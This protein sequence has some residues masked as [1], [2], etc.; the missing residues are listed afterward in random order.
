MFRRGLPAFLEVTLLVVL[1][2]I[3][4]RCRAEPLS[5]GELVRRTQECQPT[6]Q[7]YPEDIKAQIGARPIAEWG[8]EP[9]E[10][11]CEGDSLSVVFRLEGPWAT[12]DAVIPVLLKDPRGGVRRHGET[13]RDGPLVTYVFTL[14]DADTQPSWLEVLYPTGQRRIALSQ[15]GQWKK[16]E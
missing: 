9:V 13:R 4:A 11:G 5:Q 2:M 1:S 14:P 7:D 12:R 16:T 8:G 10:V 15:Q 3:V 6:W